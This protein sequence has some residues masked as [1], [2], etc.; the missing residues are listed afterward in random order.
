MST[1]TNLKNPKILFHFSLP[2]YLRRGVSFL[3]FR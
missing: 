2:S 1:D 3:L